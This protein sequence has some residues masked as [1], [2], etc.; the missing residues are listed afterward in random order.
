L[1]NPQET[2]QPFLERIGADHKAG[3]IPLPSLPAVALRVRRAVEDDR[4]GFADLA[5]LIQLDP[6]LTAQVMQSA[7]SA[8]FGGQAPVANCQ[9]A[10]ARLGLQGVRDRVVALSMKNVFAHASPHTERRLHELWQHSVR[11]AAISHVLGTIG[12]DLDSERALLAGLLHDVGVLPLLAYAEEFPA[13]LTDETLLDRVLA[14]LKGQMGTLVLK[15]WGFEEDLVR[16][17]VEAEHWTR[18]PGGMPDYAD[19]VLLANI[20]S[21]FGKGP[22]RPE[23][24]TLPA[25]QKFPLGAL[26]P[27]GGVEVLEEAQEQIR[28][29]IAMLQ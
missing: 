25:F 17:P 22:Q 2:L 6:A 28:G 3:R 7:N 15:S 11:V 1:L 16:V 14:R 20:F 12:P 9:A 13:L 18:D 5:K 10:V 23:L 26:G 4:L 27:E 29:V 8:R 19:V 21:E 24:A